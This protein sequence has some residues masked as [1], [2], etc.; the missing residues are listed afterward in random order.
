[1]QKPGDD[2]RPGDR[3]FK[4]GVQAGISRYPDYR[5]L[6]LLVRDKARY[7]A[8]RLIAKL[9]GLLAGMWG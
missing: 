8:G 4:Q 6:F 7:R 1:M 5:E 2:K 9:K 3:E